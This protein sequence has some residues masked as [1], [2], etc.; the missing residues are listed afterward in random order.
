[1]PP[2]L[3][4]TPSAKALKL[5]GATADEVRFERAIVLSVAKAPS[6]EGRRVFIEMELEEE[7]P[8]KAAWL[9]FRKPPENKAADILGLPSEQ[10]LHWLQ[11]PAD[12]SKQRRLPS[13]ALQTLGATIDDVRIEKALLVLGEAPGR[14]VPAGKLP[15]PRPY[16]DDLIESAVPRWAVAPKPIGGLSVFLCAF[17]PWGILAPLNVLK[18]QLNKAR[19]RA[20]C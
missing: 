20:P 17:L 13:K 10:P 18:L 7:S 6:P 15:R 4:S 2:A 11:R 3:S 8:K 12:D 9:P 16:L 19:A 1:M 14:E 5:L